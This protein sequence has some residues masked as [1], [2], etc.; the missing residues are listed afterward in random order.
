MSKGLEALMINSLKEMAFES[1]KRKVL[2][3]PAHN[4]IL[5]Y[6]KDYSTYCMLFETYQL[7]KKFLLKEVEFNLLSEVLKDE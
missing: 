3:I 6:A 4:Y 2:F 1:L 5:S 7:N